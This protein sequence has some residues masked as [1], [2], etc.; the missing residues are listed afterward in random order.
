MSGDRRFASRKF[1]LAMLAMVLAAAWLGL[2]LIDSEQWV[3]ATK[4]VVGLYF[5]GNIG[6]TIAT[7]LMP[8]GRP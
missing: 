6:A 3:D 1:L 8:G 7:G 4:W 2:G 5:A